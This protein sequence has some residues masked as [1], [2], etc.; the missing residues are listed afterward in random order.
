MS[1]ETFPLEPILLVDDEAAFLRS[2][3]M[4]LR[5]LGG[6]NNVVTC[7]DSRE[8]FGLL[9][10]QAFSLVVLD[11]T[12]PHLPGE[13]L[14][15][16]L[17]EKLPEIPVIILSGLNQVDTAVRCIKAGA[18]DYFV[19]TDEP[20]RLV[21]GVRRVLAARELKREFLDLKA[22]FLDSGLRIPEVFSNIVTRDHTMQAI[23]KYIEAV[24]KSSEPVLISGESGV[25]KELIARAIHDCSKPDKPWVAVNVAGLDDTVFS[26]TLFGHLK[27]AFTG[28]DR[29]RGGRVESA[30]D[31]TLF[32]DEIGDLGLPSQIKLLRLLQEGEYF[33]L[34]SDTPKRSRARF[35]CSTNVD[36]ETKIAAG[37]FRKDLFYRLQT[38]QIIIPPLR[39]R[40][41]DLPLLLNYF[42]EE[43]A[44]SMGKSVPTPP[45]ELP[46]LLGTYHFPGNIREL[47]GMIYDAVSRHDKGT[48]SMRSFQ[49]TVGHNAEGNH[50]K[51]S[52]H[53]VANAADTLAFPPRLPTLNEIADLLVEEALR[54]AQNNQ[55]IAAKMLGI[56]RQALGQRMRKKHQDES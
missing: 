18:F 55:T 36:L 30:A 45:A 32:L 40:K 21:A 20:E 43:A 38:H 11:L 51:A 52:V 25:G 9:Q 27:G 56:T 53:Q 4:T 33:P 1:N 19:K 42:L 37:S 26:D 28:A 14:L 12:M 47:R 23:F 8:V 54:R 7:Q 31:G 29:P 10:S 35:V 5:Q 16:E 24:G 22:R 6:I 13:M 48:L 41:G 44:Q 49:K 15:A 2:L 39:E 34:G 17:V 46:V 3:K 50:S